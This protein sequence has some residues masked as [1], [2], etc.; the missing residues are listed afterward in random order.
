VSPQP[1]SYLAPPK[2]NPHGPCNTHGDFR[3]RAP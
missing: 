3:I 2:K 1:L